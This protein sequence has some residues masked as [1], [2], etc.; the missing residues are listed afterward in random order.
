MSIHMFTHMSINMSIHMSIH[1]STH[2]S[3]HVS[4]H[5]SIHMSILK[6]REFIEQNVSEAS[7]NETQHEIVVRL[8]LIMDTAT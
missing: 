3:M 8:S 2:T 7:D 5:M 1:M 6:V 4:V